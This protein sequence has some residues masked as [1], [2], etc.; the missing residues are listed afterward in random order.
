LIYVDLDGVLANFVSP[1]FAVHS[2]PYLEEDWPAGEWDIARALGVSTT[3]FWK[4]IDERGSAFWANLPEYPW[5]GSLLA[6]VCKSQPQWCVL[7]S[8]SK[9]SECA[10][11]KVQWLRENCG[12]NFREYIL[13]PRHLKSLLAKPGDILIDDNDLNC[14]EFEDAGGRSILFPQP[15]NANHGLTA[16]RI[17]YVREQ[18][19]LAGNAI[20]A[21]R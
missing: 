12:F 13:A 6:N 16:D 10:K 8:P 4:K 11:G 7:S 3:E 9:N 20:D 15:W 17:G 18:L 21:T 19:V 5:G 2:R 1:A 14:Q